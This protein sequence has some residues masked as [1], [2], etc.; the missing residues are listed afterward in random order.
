MNGAAMHV[1]LDL[2]E[3]WLRGWSGARGLPAPVRH[4]G[5]LTVE[6]GWPEQLRRHV[7]LDAGAALQ[8]CAG[9]VR[10]AHVHIKAAVEPEVL[11]RAL[12]PGWTLESPRA[13]M[14]TT[15]PMRPQPLPA[16]YRAAYAT[17]HGTCVLH[18]LDA[19]GSS[20]ATGRLHLHE[21][22][23]VFDR[24]ETDPAHR[25]RGLASAVMGLLD[26][27]AVEAGAQERLLVASEQG[28]ALYLG[29]GWQVLAPYSTAISPQLP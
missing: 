5:G 1:S 29:L 3:R 9:T 15:G 23:A 6:V 26:A 12:P 17:E 10:Q 2:L 21:G 28:R 7:F 11:L 8:A 19:H 14:A 20:A 18:L 13:L 22:C 27:V 25:R 16:G 4:G 24:I